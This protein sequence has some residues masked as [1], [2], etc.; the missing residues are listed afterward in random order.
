MKSAGWGSVLFSFSFGLRRPDAALA[1]GGLTPQ[2]T[3]KRSV[4]SHQ[5]N[6]KSGVK[7]PQSKIRT[8]AGCGSRRLSL[9][10]GAVLVRTVGQG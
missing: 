8:I 9:E 2:S 1:A 10:I 7:P 4:L 3:P 5:G 6:L